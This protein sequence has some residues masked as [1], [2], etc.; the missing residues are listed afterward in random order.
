MFEGGLF[1]LAV[2]GLA[3]AVAT[4]KIGELIRG[5]PEHPKRFGRIPFFG[6][7][8]FCPTCLA[9]WIGMIFSHFF[10]SPSSHVMGDGWRAVIIDGLAASGAVYLIHLIAE[11]LYQGS[12]PL[13]L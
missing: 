12:G 5:T 8:F 9:F 10:L 13:D 4:L 6:K 3:N 2:F 11:R 1:L 7:A